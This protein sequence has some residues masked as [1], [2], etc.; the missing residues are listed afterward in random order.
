MTVNEIIHALRTCA[1][2][3]CSSCP[4]RGKINCHLTMLNDAADA[5]ETLLLFHAEERG[6]Q[7]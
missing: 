1:T 6:E 7:R 5:M 2:P 4:Y 3:T